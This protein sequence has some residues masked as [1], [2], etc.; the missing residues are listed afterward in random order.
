MD[1][2]QAPGTVYDILPWFDRDPAFS[3]LLFISSSSSELRLVSEASPVVLTRSNG[4]DDRLISG[5]NCGTTTTPFPEK[6][7]WS[8]RPSSLDSI[9]G[10]VCSWSGSCVCLGVGSCSRVLE[11]CCAVLKSWAGIYGAVGAVGVGSL[12]G[13]KISKV[14]NGVFVTETCYAYPNCVDGRSIVSTGAVLLF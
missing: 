9:N 14:Y 7:S 5:S 6:I 12:L 8:S 11:G 3:L 4:I 10:C 2:G 13:L 1:F